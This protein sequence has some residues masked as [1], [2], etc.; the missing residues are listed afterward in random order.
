[1]QF[2]RCTQRIQTSGFLDQLMTYILGVPRQIVLNG[3]IEYH[4]REQAHREQEEHGCYHDSAPSVQV[5][6]HM[7]SQCVVI[8]HTDTIL[9]AQFPPK[10]ILFLLIFCQNS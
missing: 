3:G 5:Y 4:Q 7:F 6:V 9:L 1:M 10:R 8:Q 2:Q